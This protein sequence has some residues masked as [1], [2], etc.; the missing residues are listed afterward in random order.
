M[1]DKYAVELDPEKVAQ[2]EKEKIAAGKT[3]SSTDHPNTNIPLDPK[4]GSLPLEK[5][6]VGKK[7]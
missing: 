2:M 7:A 6:P 5:E 4:L 3:S 1:M